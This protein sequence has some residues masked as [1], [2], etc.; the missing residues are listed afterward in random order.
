MESPRFAGFFLATGK[1]SESLYLRKP[2]MGG[3]CEGRA[4][5]RIKAV[6]NNEVPKLHH[7]SRVYSDETI[8]SM[9]PNSRDTQN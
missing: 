6:K 8:E 3:N 7:E 9:V 4:L 1:A 5:R 2:P